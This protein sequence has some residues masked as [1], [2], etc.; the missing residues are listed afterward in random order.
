MV[1]AQPNKTD[2]E[3]MVTAHRPHPSSPDMDLLSVQVDRTTPIDGEH[4]LLT[5]N[6]DPIV[7]VMAPRSA[8]PA[9]DLT[10]RRLRF[11]AS[12]VGP[13]V[14]RLDSTVPPEMP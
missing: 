7:D 9:T 11:R 4:D 12:L 8:L 13:G 3:G 10:G 5:G 2:L 1:Q 6:L 14:I